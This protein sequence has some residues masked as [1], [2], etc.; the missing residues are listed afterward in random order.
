MKQTNQNSQLL[1]VAELLRQAAESGQRVSEAFSQMTAR[2][3]REYMR[4]RKLAKSEATQNKSAMPS[5]N[6]GKHHRLSGGRS[7]KG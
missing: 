7:S 2:G 5:R 4:H 1:Q 3:R 6:I